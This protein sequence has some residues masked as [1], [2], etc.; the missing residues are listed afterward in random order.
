[1]SINKYLDYLKNTLSY[2]DA[3]IKTYRYILDNFVASK[4]SPEKYLAQFSGSYRNR[5]IN[6]LSSYYAYLV[7]TG[8]KTKNEVNDIKRSKQNKKVPKFASADKLG[9]IIDSIKE[10]GF[11]NLRN[12]ALLEFGIAVGARISEFT[13]VKMTDLDM[14]NKK[15]KIYGK[16]KERIQDLTDTAVDILTKYLAER[17]KI[18]KCDYLFI[19]EQGEQLKYPYYAIKPLIGDLT[20]HQFNRHSLAIG[21]IR[22]GMDL[23]QVSKVLRHSSI[24]TTAIYLS[25][26]DPSIQE[27]LKKKHPRSK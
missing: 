27:Q 26:E 4:K 10:E 8:V 5:N 12:K 22:N 13:Y 9:K 11:I 25:A 21:L 1:M 6:I 14:P 18:T 7:K 15:V 17:A 20:P 16:G 3:T 24:N 19:T 2:K 23:Y